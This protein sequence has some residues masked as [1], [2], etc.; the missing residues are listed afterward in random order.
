MIEE[1]EIGENNNVG[2]TG[3]QSM[4]DSVES[5][6]VVLHPMHSQV[7]PYQLESKKASIVGV[8]SRGSHH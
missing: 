3:H 7:N 4:K 6:Q 1:S 2:Y 8:Q 5:M